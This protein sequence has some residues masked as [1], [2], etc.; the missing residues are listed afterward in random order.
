[1][2]KKS[3]FSI[4][5]VTA[6]SIGGSLWGSVPISAA[7]VIQNDY[8][9][10]PYKADIEY[11]VQH[12]L[13]W[14]FP[15]GNFR[16]D[17]PVTQAD[18]VTSLTAV[19]GLTSGTPVME[20]PANHW[21]MV[22][23]ER[24]RKDGILDGV[25][26]NPT[27][28]LNRE[29]ASQLMV[30]AWKS[31]RRT[32]QNPMQYFIGDAVTSKWLPAKPG[33]FPNG[34]ST[35]TLDS[36]GS[37]TRG[38]Q[39]VAMHLLHTDLSGIAS[40]EKIALQFHNSL[41]VSGSMAKGHIQAVKGYDIRLLVVTKDRNVVE[42]TSGN[43]SFNVNNTAFAEYSVKRS[44]ESTPLSFYYYQSFPSLERTNRR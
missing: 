41:K 1:M 38:E 18:L 5:I 37:V 22:Y 20:L 3:M 23:Y 7:Q 25:D 44:G 39:A 33:Y 2:I 30:N 11:A 21:A 16:P 17:Q 19:K 8:Q 6:L 12:K 36:M 43:V 31:V 4:S 13:M 26:I 32:Y 40:A 10:H 27:K 34:V 35:T 28:V 29:E 42:F 9:T 15:D 14:L 24:A